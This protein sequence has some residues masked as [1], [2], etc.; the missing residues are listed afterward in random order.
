MPA[1]VPAPTPAPAPPANVTASIVVGASGMSST[2]YNPNPI[3]VA[4]GGTVTWRNDDSITHTSTANNVAWNS[5]IIPPGGSFSAQFNSAGSF[6]YHC[7][8]H[9]NM[10]GVVNVR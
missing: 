9:P 1:P 3:E 2:A 4:V 7:T 10:V 6:P 8:I 5:G